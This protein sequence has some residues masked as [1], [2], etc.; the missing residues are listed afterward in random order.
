MAHASVFEGLDGITNVGELDIE[1]VLAERST[2]SNA[3][4]RRI[5]VRLG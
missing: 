4:A 5:V 2:I 1:R 3:T